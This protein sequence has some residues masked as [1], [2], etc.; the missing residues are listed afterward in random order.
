[1]NAA[2]QKRHDKAVARFVKTWEEL[3]GYTPRTFKFDEM[4]TTEINEFTDGEIEEHSVNK[5]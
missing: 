5:S 3:N 1:M 2:E 4:T